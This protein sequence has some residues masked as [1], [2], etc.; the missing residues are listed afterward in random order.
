RADAGVADRAQV[1]HEP[2]IRDPIEARVVA[3]NCL[4]GLAPGVA[5]SPGDDAV[6]RRHDDAE[7]P[8]AIGWGRRKPERRPAFGIGGAGL[9]ARAAVPRPLDTGA[10]PTRGRCSGGATSAMTS[11]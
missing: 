9:G 1:T 8:R 3:E 5:A 11:R 7:D 10:V 4:H 2:A 6:G